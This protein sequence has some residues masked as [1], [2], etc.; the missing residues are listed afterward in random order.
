[1]E[2]ERSHC[3][4]FDASIA[5]SITGGASGLGA[6]MAQRLTRHGVKVALS[7][8]NVEVT[9]SLLTASPADSGTN[10]GLQPQRGGSA[11]SSSIR[12]S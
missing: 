10:R 2:N 3:M 6:A 4:Q 11:R 7:D 12:L 8:L 1:V 5:A 9:S